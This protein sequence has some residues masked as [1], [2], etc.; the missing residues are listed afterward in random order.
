M[1]LYSLRKNSEFGPVLKGH[2]F[3]RA[4]NA[5]EST[6]LEPL[7]GARPIARKIRIFQQGA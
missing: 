1:R 5:A 2:E 6:R 7:R 4:N 3:T